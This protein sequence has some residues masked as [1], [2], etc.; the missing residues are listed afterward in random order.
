MPALFKEQV[1]E[2]EISDDAKNIT[3]KI[4]VENLVL[5]NIKTKEE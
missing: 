2:Q 5:A 3:P 4:D 1:K